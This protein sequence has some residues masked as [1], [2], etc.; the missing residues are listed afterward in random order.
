MTVLAYVWLAVAIAM[1]VVEGATA[2][3][4]SATATAALVSAATA[5][6]SAAATAASHAARPPGRSRST[7]SRRPAAETVTEQRLI[8]AG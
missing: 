3:L 4:V 7:S 1:G 5:L 6:E 8:E 2:A